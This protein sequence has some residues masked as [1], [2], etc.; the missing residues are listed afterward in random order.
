[1][2]KK[3]DIPIL[4]RLYEEE[5][6]VEPEF[7]LPIIPMCLVNGSCG[8]GTGH[9]TL[10][11]RYNPRDLCK[12]I[13]NKASGKTV[14]KLKPWYRGFTGKIEFSVV[15]KTKI[16]EHSSIDVPEGDNLEEEIFDT[17][18][19]TPALVS[20]GCFTVDPKGMVTVTELPIGRWTYNYLK[21][22]E[23]LR[24]EGT[25]KS[26]RNLSTSDKVY[27]E[28]TGLNKPDVNN[29][30]L[31]KSF[32]MSNMVLLDAPNN[33]PHQF[34]GGSDEIM[35]EFYNRRL[36]YFGLRREHMVKVLNE[37]ISRK[38]TDAK[39]ISLVKGKKINML[40]HTDINYPI[41]TRE[42]IPHDILERMTLI[43]VAKNKVDDL[44][45]EIQKLETKRDIIANKT[46]EEMWVED[47]DAFLVEYAKYEK[48]PL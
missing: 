48:R 19:E 6:E 13:K 26:L 14:T 28:I 31:V 35:E 4:K 30:H 39:F 24:E 9:A 3:D 1:V 45:N 43:R 10:I 32:G 27:F 25:I 11:P 21:E 40:D 29:L 18:E 38:K 46:Q 15:K 23:R 41:L 36:P 47:I 34:K 22:L 37:D 17:P 7:F 44:L 5:T 12:W 2:F 16:K 8:I 20:K 42:G 33:Y